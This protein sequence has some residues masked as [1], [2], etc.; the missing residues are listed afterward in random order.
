[1]TKIY[2]NKNERYFYGNEINTYF[3]FDNKDK[4]CELKPCK[5]NRIFLNDKILTYYEID[6]KAD[7]IFIQKNVIDPKRFNKKY[8]QIIEIATEYKTLYYEKDNEI[9]Y[10]LINDIEN[11]YEKF[12]G[13]P[14][15]LIDY[16][17]DKYFTL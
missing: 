2:S 9:N 13:I 11:I 12:E 3:Y 10:L 5:D 7:K 1:M 4:I 8:N 17:L 15:K 14:V 16:I 6:K